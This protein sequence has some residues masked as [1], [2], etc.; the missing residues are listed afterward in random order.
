MDKFLIPYGLCQT[1]EGKPP[2]YMA[3]DLQNTDTVPYNLFISDPAAGTT[4]QLPYSLLSGDKILVKQSEKG[5][6]SEYKIKITE[7]TVETDDGTCVDYPN[8]NH[9]SYSDCIDAELRGKIVPVLGCMVPWMSEG[10][11]CSQPVPRLAKHTALVQWISNI[12]LAS[13]GDI[14]FRSDACLPPCRTLS[15]HV[16][17]APS[18]SSR[19]KGDSAVCL[20]FQETIDMRAIVLAYDATSLLVEVGSCLGLWLGLSVVGI[21][22]ACTV[23]MAKI[24]RVATRSLK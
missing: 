15:F 10:G 17:K 3:L 4:F 20:Y 1:F 11:A 19:P 13:W 21:F 12:S 2:A 6:W 16:S 22:D 7:N 18:D 23:I 8:A 9:E 24:K 5:S 14:E